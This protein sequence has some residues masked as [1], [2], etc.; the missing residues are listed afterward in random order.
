M[1]IVDMASILK[2]VEDW[3]KSDTGQKRMKATI[4]K[5]IRTNVKTTQAGD[6]VLTI[7][8][9]KEMSNILIRTF[10][11]HSAGL[12]SSV[13]AHFGSLK[14][15]PPKRLSDGSYSIEI[16]FADDLSRASLQP[17]DYGGARNIIAIFNNGYPNNGGSSEAISHVSGFW[18]GEYVHARGSREGLH[19]MQAAV[20]EFNG[21]YGSV[22]DVY[23]T[24]ASVYEG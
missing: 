10:V 11:K 21:T 12:P 7:N 20:D 8:R 6:S 15:T 5:Y 4:D 16:S 17:Y 19:F 14:A 22:Y 18:H 1:A 24:L 23:V 2:K 13:A 3:E 9:M